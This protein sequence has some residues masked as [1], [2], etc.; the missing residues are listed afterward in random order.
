MNTPTTPTKASAPPEDEIND[1]PLPSMPLKNMHSPGGKPMAAVSAA[2]VTTVPQV[3]AATPITA[4]ER[5]RYQS[6]LQLQLNQISA[7]NQ[8]GM[9]H[10]MHHGAGE[11]ARIQ[12]RAQDIKYQRN[13][14]DGDFEFVS[15]INCPL[16]CYENIAE[17]F[18][19]S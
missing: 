3:P 8:M 5:Q 14:V 15:L 7:A 11:N 19:F 12:A 4:D 6:H 10:L 2:P 13:F 1:L 17:L 9:Q 16:I 18:I